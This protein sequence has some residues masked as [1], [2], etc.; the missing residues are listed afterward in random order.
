MIFRALASPMPGRVASSSAEAEF[1][2]M[3]S[4][5]LAGSATLALAF[6]WGG[7]VFVAWVNPAEAGPSRTARLIDRRAPG[8]GVRGENM[9]DLALEGGRS[10]GYAASW[11]VRV[12]DVDGCH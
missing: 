6:A 8:R 3:G 12:P 2:S 11:S 5:A 9:D 1:R 4:W 10:R 7:A